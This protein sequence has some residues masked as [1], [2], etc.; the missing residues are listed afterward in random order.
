M[1]EEIICKCGHS[2]RDH[3]NDVCLRILPDPKDCCDCNLGRYEVVRIHMAEQLANTQQ[4]LN[5]AKSA[6]ET[7]KGR[8]VRLREALEPFANEGNDWGLNV[9]N[10]CIPIIKMD[11]SEDDGD[12]LFTVGDLRNA[13]IVLK[14]TA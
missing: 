9:P 13:G 11:S 8:V 12:A 7:E 2:E 4:A 14:E 10:S 1:N 6:Y 3:N 5:L